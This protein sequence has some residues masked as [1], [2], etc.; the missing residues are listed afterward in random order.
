MR[1]SGSTATL[2]GGVNALGQRTDPYAAFNFWVEIG[3]LIAGGFT[4]VS[5]LQIETETLAYREGGLNAYVHH[6]PGPTRYPQNLVLKRGL[7]DIDTL[8]A[9]YQDVSNGTIRRW[10]GTIYLLKHNGETA[11][12]WDFLEAYPVRWIGPDLRSDSSNVAF[13]SI[14]LV[15]RGIKKSAAS[16]PAP[17]RT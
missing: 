13:E 14:E 9:W 7:T 2:G 6:L 5:G 4:E 10:N 17:R 8:W 3:N 12:A 16:R 15:H 11:L 1:T